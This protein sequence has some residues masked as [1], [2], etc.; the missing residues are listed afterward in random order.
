VWPISWITD[1]I[2]EKAFGPLQK[3]RTQY[4][5]SSGLGIWGAKFRIGTQSEYIMLHVKPSNRQCLTKKLQ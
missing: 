2:Y 4:Y 1:A 5:M 3:G